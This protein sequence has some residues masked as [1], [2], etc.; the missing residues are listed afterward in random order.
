MAIGAFDP[1]N[2][3]QFDLARGI[4]QG[5]GERM[6]VIPASVLAEVSHAAGAAASHAIARSIGSACGER[7]AARFGGAEDVRSASIDDVLSHLAGELAIAGVGTT[8]LER[9]GRAL[10]AVFG[11]CPISDS[12]AVAELLGAALVAA[13]ERPVAALSLGRDAGGVRVLVANKRAVERAK[14]WL[15]QGS[16]WGDVLAKLQA[17]G[18]P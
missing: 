15:A 5:G 2:A 17:R 18:E 1:T 8:H 9:W 14:E 12:A 7:V 11:S 4:V 6:L 10:V 16:S 13:T 3:V